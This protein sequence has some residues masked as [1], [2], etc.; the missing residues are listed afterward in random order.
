MFDR[1]LRFSSLLY[2]R[3]DLLIVIVLNRIGKGIKKILFVVCRLVRHWADIRIF[4]LD[5]EPLLLGQVVE[6]VVDVMSVCNILFEAD[7]CKFLEGS[8]LMDHLVEIVR[9]VEYSGIC[10]VWISFGRLLR[11]ITRAVLL[12]VT[13]CL[14]REIG[15]FINLWAVQHFSFDGVWCQLNVETPLFDLFALSNHLVELADAVNTVI[16]LLE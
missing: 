5:L 1:L 2:N 6:L 13:T 7:N 3:Q 9:I 10:R 15:S 12:L 4:D 16:W 8:R 14:S 11:T